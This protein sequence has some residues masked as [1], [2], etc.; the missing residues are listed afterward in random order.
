MSAKKT[1]VVTGTEHI[2][3]ATV[4]AHDLR[5]GAALVIAGLAAEGETVVSGYDYIARGYEDICGA[6]LKL[7]AAIVQAEENDR[8]DGEKL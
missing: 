8:K 1:A 5:A 7:G 2:Y 4:S 3:G 6:L